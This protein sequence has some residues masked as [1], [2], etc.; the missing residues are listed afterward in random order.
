MYLFFSKKIIS[1]ILSSTQIT[2][3]PYFI[4]KIRTTIT[5]KITFTDN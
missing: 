1:D 3:N 5:K 2:T 4:I